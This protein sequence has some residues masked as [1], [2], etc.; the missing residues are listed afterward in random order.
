MTFDEVI[1]TY[2]MKIIGNRDENG[3]PLFL[4]LHGGGQSDTPE[5]NNSQWKEMGLYYLEGVTNGIYVNPRGVRDTWDTH[6]NPESY[7]LYDRLIM[8]MIAF[9]DADPNRVYLTGFSAGGDGVYAIIARMSDRFAAANM[10]AGHPNGVSLKNLYNTPLILQV[11]ENDSE[12]NRNTATAQYNEILDNYQ[13]EFDGGYP[14]K[15]FIHKSKPHNFFDNKIMLQEVMENCGSWLKSGESSVC[16]TDTNAI[17]L[18]EKFV[19]DPIPKKIVWDL[20][21]RADKRNMKSFYWLSADLNI[22]EGLII[23]SY[24]RGSNSINVEKCTAKGEISF[25]INEDMLD[26]FSPIKIKLPTNSIS[27]KVMANY[28]LLYET[29]V[30][31]GD[32]NY[33]FVAKIT[34]NL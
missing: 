15:C 23:A 12:Y 34:I 8:N 20:S 21:H 18:L 30:E 24:D 9:Y 3:Y 2:E 10:S 7:P 6:F 28:D 29:M 26:V 17:H 27:V 4:C 25:L 16:N 19:R 1:M 32:Y 31:R 14:H 11:G 33:Q 5:L 13:I 22:K